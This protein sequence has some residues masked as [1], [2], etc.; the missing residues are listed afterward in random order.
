MTPKRRRPSCELC[1]KPA[2][3]RGWC[4]SHYNRWH[5]TGDPL[6]RPTTR[7]DRYWRKVDTSGGDD[8]CWPW[9]G[10]RNPLGYGR[11]YAD[12]KHQLAHRFGFGLRGHPLTPEEVVMHACDNP[13]CQNPRHL[14]AGTTADNTADMIAKGRNK[15]PP[16]PPPGNFRRYGIRDAEWMSA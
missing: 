7:A 8:A 15:L 13:P 14:T 5:R 16:P 3:C 6:P 4:R 2:H 10:L 9:T 11:I 12:G 1:E